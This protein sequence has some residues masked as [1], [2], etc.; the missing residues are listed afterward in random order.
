MKTLFVKL[1]IANQREIG[2]PCECKY[3]KESGESPKWDTVAIEV[4][5]KDNTR[6]FGYSWS[7][8]MPELIGMKIVES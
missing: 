5:G 4:D 1:P 3:C 8:H 7:V 6:F 2:Y